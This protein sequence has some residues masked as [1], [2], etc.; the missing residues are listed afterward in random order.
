M[1]SE[2]VLDVAVVG[3]GINGAGIAA[4]AS[5][6]GLKVG[7]YEADDFAS[8]TSSA[9]SKLIHGGLRYL[10]HYEFRLVRKALAEREIML[11]KAPFIVWPMR[12]CLPDRPHFRPAWMIRAGLFLYDN[13]GQRT[14]LPASQHIVFDND[15]VL[16]R[17]ISQGFMYSDCWGDDARL[18]IVNIMDAAERGAEVR[19]RCKV[20][21]AERIDGLWQLDIL[22]LQTQHHFQR[23]SKVLVNAAGPWVN[24]FFNLSL[25]I[26]SPCAIRLVKGSHLVVPRVHDQ[27]LAYI[28]QNQ[29]GR[30]VFVLPYLDRFSI[31]GTTDVEFTGDPRKVEIDDDEF[32]YLLGVY[33]QHFQ[34]QL[35]RNDVV[36]TFSGVR[37]LYDDLSQSPQMLTRDYI[38]KMDNPENQ[39]PL[40]SVFGGKLTTY[41]VLAQAAVNKFSG[42]FPKIGPAWTAKSVLPGGENIESYTDVEHE[43]SQRFS[44]MD[45]FTVHRLASTYGSRVWVWL[46]DVI[47]N[48]DLGRIFGQGLSQK[49]VDYLIEVEFVQCAEDLLWRR[50]KLGLYLSQ[51]QQNELSEYIAQ[52]DRY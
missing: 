18:V 39:A 32:T 51:S 17:E 12:F 30:I 4:D 13:L 47:E 35:C 5:G 20:L 25:S 46:V 26:T 29:D 33:N 10:E 21:K 36:W 8:A 41:R 22:D 37:S 1:M 27:D 43:L 45:T 52:Y 11:K 14:R 48:T 50:T 15:S 7:L 40:L 2:S 44:W 34:H 16:K 28:L 23:T 3:G 19:N 6:R 31:I 24:Q 38:L 49:E 9:S 42:Y